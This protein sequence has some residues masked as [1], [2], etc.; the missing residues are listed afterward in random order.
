MSITELVVSGL[1]VFGLLAIP[2]GPAEPTALAVG[3]A[4][5][6]LDVP[7][8]LSIAVIAAG[9][10]VGD[11]IV[12]CTATAFT[13]RCFRSAGARNKLNRWRATLHGRPL[14]RD[15]MILVLRF[16]PGARTPAAILA[17]NSGISIVRFCVLTVLGAT[18]WATFWI[19]LVSIV[20]RLPWQLCLG[21][22]LVVIGSVLLSQSIRTTPSARSPHSSRQID[23][24]HY[25]AGGSDRA[26]LVPRVDRSV[27]PRLVSVILLCCL[28]A[29]GPKFFYRRPIACRCRNPQSL[30]PRGQFGLPCH[31]LCP[32]CCVIQDSKCCCPLFGNSGQAREFL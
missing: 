18:C 6:G 16:I 21:V 22:L 3:V 20:G 30:D 5:A 15:A 4:T 23:R 10:F 17:A 14:G 12:Y 26:E 1:M 8:W 24:D 11:L 13:D 32:L 28:M 27:M 9:M 2:M 19:G 25:P 31:V 7:L 29:H